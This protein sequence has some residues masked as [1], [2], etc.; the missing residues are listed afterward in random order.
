MISEITLEAAQRDRLGKNASRA[1]RRAGQVPVTLYGGEDRSALAL[2]VNRRQLLEIFRSASGRN[3]IFQ[4]KLH[5]GAT[6]VIVKDWQSEPINGSLL[7]AD[8]IRI[9]L[10]KPTRVKV[11]VKLSGEAFGVKTEGGLLDFVMHTVEVECLPTD[12]PE[13]LSADIS[14]LRIGDHLSAKD[15]HLPEGVRMLM[16][17]DRVIVGVLAPRLEEEPAPVVAVAAGETAEPEVI[18]KGKAETPEEEGAEKK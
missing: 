11:D 9:D 6:P 15:L 7:H 5:G 17:P 13:L 4:L 12:I 16:D 1:L 18:K 8:L 3:T 14:G 10:A 2:S